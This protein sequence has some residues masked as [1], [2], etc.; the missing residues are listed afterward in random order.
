MLEKD[1]VMLSFFFLSGCLERREGRMEN[2]ETK[3]TVRQE[4][5]DWVESVM[6]ALSFMI[7]LFVFVVGIVIVNG[8][9]M[10]DTLHEGERLATLP[11]FYQAEQGDIV[12]IHR[13]GNTPIIK[14]VIATGGQTVD[15]NFET[16]Q[17]MVDG[18]VL[19]EPY[20]SSESPAYNAEEMQ[21]FPA[22]VPEGCYFVMGDNRA[23]SLDS[24]FQEIGMIREE[25]IFGEVICRIYPLDAV[26]AD[27]DG[28][29]G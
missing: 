14:R 27:F 2:G 10:D 12:V 1:G 6:I 19:D 20:V 26:G 21:Q 16:G 25:Q 5:V 18:T 9:S 23:R 3:P 29:E 13:E 15:I 22:T 28:V 4:L 7:F 8:D 24:R 17:V 11:V